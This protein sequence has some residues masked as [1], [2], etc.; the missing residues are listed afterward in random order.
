MHRRQTAPTPCLTNNPPCSPPPL[1]HQ[2]APVYYPRAVIVDV[3]G[4]TGGVSFNRGTSALQF[5]PSSSSAAAAST[6]GGPV[7]VH[8]AGQVPKSAFVQQLELQSRLDYS[9]GVLFLKLSCCVLGWLARWTDRPAALCSCPLLSL[10]HSLPTTS[11]PSPISPHNTK[12]NTTVSQSELARH[13]AALEAAARQLD[14][15]SSSSTAAAAAAAVNT[16]PNSSSSS[17]MGVGVR[18]WTDYL[19]AQLHPRSVQA[20]SGAW[21]G[22]GGFDGYG[23]AEGL[24]HGVKGAVEAAVDQVRWWGEQCDSLQGVQ[25]MADD[26]TGFGGLTRSVLDELREEL[27][28]VKM[29]FFSVRA[30]EEERRSDG[31]TGSSLASA[32]YDV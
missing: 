13:Q 23:A 10:T 2:G 7:Q 8:A 22:S 24:L 5:N 6:W 29:L 32:R 25:I 11:N 26:L 12:T 16:N 15:S 19:K 4:A 30:A 28:G 21:R 3:S 31:S 17:A 27:P 18:Y 14:A 1:T 20:L 9:T